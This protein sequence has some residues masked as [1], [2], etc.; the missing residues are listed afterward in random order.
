MTIKTYTIND[1]YTMN[2]VIS[3]NDILLN[4]KHY[5]KIKSQYYL[6][7]YKQIFKKWNGN[8]DPQLATKI[9]IYKDI[10]IKKISE[11]ETLIEN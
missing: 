6:Y 3:I 7:K 11:L 5:K 2:K 10:A 1:D 9:F 8:E 4:S